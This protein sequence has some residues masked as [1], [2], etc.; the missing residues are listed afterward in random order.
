MS[1]VGII[2]CDWVLPLGYIC[3]FMHSCCITARVKD[4]M[5]RMQIHLWWNME[6]Q[7]GTHIIQVTSGLDYRVTIQIVYC[8]INQISNGKSNLL[9]RY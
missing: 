3:M 5:L 2:V 4:I 8:Y 6:L 9:T 7:D 1:T